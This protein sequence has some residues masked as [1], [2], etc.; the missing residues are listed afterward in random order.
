MKILNMSG[1]D[2][3]AVEI[4]EKGGLRFSVNEKDIVMELP[5][6]RKQNKAEMDRVVA[7]K[8][9]EL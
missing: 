2:R 1:L 8:V 9:T 4:Y 5:E 3:N 6:A 7:A